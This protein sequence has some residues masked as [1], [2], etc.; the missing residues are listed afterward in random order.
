VSAL[1]DFDSGVFEAALD[2]GHGDDRP[3]RR[4]AAAN[5]SIKMRTQ[6]A[7]AAGKSR[8]VVVDVSPN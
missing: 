2:A 7:L 1:G 3:S 5:A 4:V 8:H 6:T